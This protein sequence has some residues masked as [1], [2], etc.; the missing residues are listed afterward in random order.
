MRGFQILKLMYGVVVEVVQEFE[1]VIAHYVGL[2]HHGRVDGAA[3]NPVQGFR[4]RI[5]SHDRN[6]AAEIEAVQ[7]IGGAS[8]PGGFQANDSV[9]IIFGLHDGGYRV[10]ENGSKVRII[11]E[12]FAR[13]R[14]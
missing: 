2:L 12:A 4:V 6:L 11:G 8:S 3:L 7:R 13:I 1:T 9:R 14:I 10:V 5:E